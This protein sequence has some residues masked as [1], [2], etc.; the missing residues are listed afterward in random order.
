M[1]TESQKISGKTDPHGRLIHLP[2]LLTL[3]RLACIPVVVLCLYVPGRIGS[4][5]AAIFFGLASITDFLDG[6]FARRYGAV[7][8]LG[9]F[10]DPLADKILI[11]VTMIMLIPLDRIPA[12]MVT[13]IIAREI[14]LTGLRGIAVTEGIVI[15]ASALGK[16][17]TIFQSVA[18]VGLLLHYPYF[19]V[20][21]Q[22]VGMVFLW[23]A[24]IFTVWSAGE[25]F[26]RFQQILVQ[27]YGKRL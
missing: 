16:Y 18:L 5:M 23:G 26:W 6:F 9:K 19:G 7:T 2:N 27:Q 8:A 1:K 21:F 17:K 13:V 22:V 25:Y 4:L 20:N 11:S 24:L 3:A 12:W 10:L 14:A 15:Q